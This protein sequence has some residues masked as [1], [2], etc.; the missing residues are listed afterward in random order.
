L[1]LPVAPERLKA[2]FPSLD[3]DD[4]EAYAEVT[5]HL[6]TAREGKGRALSEVMAAA[7]R[8]RE[9][10]AAGATPDAGEARALR[11]L[12]ALEKMQG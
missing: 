5:Q 1:K 11:Y 3:D 10:G 6:L 7:Q 8:A 9:K 2:R 4:L 12:R